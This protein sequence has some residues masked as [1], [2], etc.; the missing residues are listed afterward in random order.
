[1]STYG[2]FDTCG[3]CQQPPHTHTQRST[4]TML[5]WDAV[6]CVYY[7]GGSG[8][9]EGSVCGGSDKRFL[10]PPPPVST[11]SCSVFSPVNGG[12]GG[13]GGELF[14]MRSHGMPFSAL[15]SALT[16]CFPFTNK[17]NELRVLEAPYSCISFLFSCFPPTLDHSHSS[18]FFYFT[19]LPSF[20]SPSHPFFVI[21]LTSLCLSFTLLLFTLAVVLSLSTPPTHR[22]TMPTHSAP[23]LTLPTLDSLSI[24]NFSLRPDA[25][26]RNLLPSLR[27]VGKRSGSNR[28]TGVCRAV[29][30]SSCLVFCLHFTRFLTVAGLKVGFR[31]SL[32]CCLASPRPSMRPGVALRWHTR[33]PAGLISP[34]V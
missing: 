6:Q 18:P 21:F 5:V 25:N 16:P 14:L 33:P 7:K 11:S 8:R 27:S 13:G 3:G 19:S 1:M 28:C 22:T 12:S 29:L 15:H 2:S 4:H 30:L 9:G 17:N 20:S 23:S 10:K 34:I 26:A 32:C 31:K 24:K